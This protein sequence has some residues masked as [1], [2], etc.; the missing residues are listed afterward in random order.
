MLELVELRERVADLEAELA[1]L[2][3]TKAQ[4]ELKL[5]EATGLSPGT[6]KMLLALS[7]GGIM[8]RVQLL[9][10]GCANGE[11]NDVRLVDSQIKRLRKK[12]PWI[13]VITH[14]G[15]GYELAPESVKKV[16]EL[17]NSRPQQSGRFIASIENR[18]SAP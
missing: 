18:M 11:D 13:R 4:D 5:K 12:A 3:N 7:R 9:C 16:R 17:I 10:H 14:Y 8:S 2:K 6:S 1:D 15:Y